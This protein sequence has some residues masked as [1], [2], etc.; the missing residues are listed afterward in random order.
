MSE[1]MYV[2]ALPKTWIINS[3]HVAW[4][5]T[6]KVSKQKP[7]CSYGQVEIYTFTGFLNFFLL[8]FV[9]VVAVV[10]VFFFGFFSFGLN[11]MYDAWIG[12]QVTYMLFVNCFEFLFI[13]FVFFLKMFFNNIF[14]II[15]GVFSLQSQRRCRREFHIC[16]Y[17]KLKF[18]N[19]KF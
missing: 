12:Y 3:K 10:H 15:F 13:A 7:L 9:L 8:W 2:R 5:A 1:S 6:K 11:F 16:G 19:K 4:T 18:L 14:I 17:S